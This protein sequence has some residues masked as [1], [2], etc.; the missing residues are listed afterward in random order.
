MMDLSKS[1][2]RR[3]W[4]KHL[5]R[6]LRYVQKALDGMYIY[7]SWGSPVLFGWVLQ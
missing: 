1:L 2:K 6:I 5:L 7:V 3:E 4:M